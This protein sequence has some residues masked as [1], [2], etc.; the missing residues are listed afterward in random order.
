[1]SVAVGMAHPLTGPPVPADPVQHRIEQGRDDDAAERGG[2][3][4]GRPARVAQVAGDELALELEAGDEE[5][6]RQ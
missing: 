6:D 3:R 2:D 5:E 4:D 1:M